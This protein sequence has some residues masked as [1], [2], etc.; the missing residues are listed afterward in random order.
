M[1]AKGYPIGTVS[2]TNSCREAKK[3]DIALLSL[4]AFNKMEGTQLTTKILV[5]G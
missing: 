4:E 5:N 1:T 3:R 2:F